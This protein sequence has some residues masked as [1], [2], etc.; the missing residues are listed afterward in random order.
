[1]TSSSSNNGMGRSSSSSKLQT[2]ILSFSVPNFKT[3]ELHDS[4]DSLYSSKSCAISSKLNIVPETD[5]NQDEIKHVDGAKTCELTATTGRES[6]VFTQNGK[7][8]TLNNDINKC[9]HGRRPAASKL[10]GV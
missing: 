10:R 1:M 5:D 9:K 8:A 4:Q 3:F 2:F 6:A 7:T